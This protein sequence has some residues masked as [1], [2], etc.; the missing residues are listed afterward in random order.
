[1]NTAAAPTAVVVEAGADTTPT[2][3]TTEPT[4]APATPVPEPTATPA[5]PLP[6]SEGM[7]QVAPGFYSI[8]SSGESA[9]L[10]EFWIDRFEVTNAQ[11]AEFIQ[12]T[13]QAAPDYWGAA[14]IPGELGGH[15]VE[16]ITWQ[17]A[18]DFCNWLD[19]RLPTEA[20]WEAAARGPEGWLYPWG[21]VRTA[22][23]LPT[24]GTYP[25]GSIA[26]NRSFF[27][28]FDMAGNVWEWVDQ[29]YEE[30][31]QGQEVI[32]GGANN[33]QND[34][35]FRAVGDPESSNMFANAGIRCAAE[36]VDPVPDALL[37]MQDDFADLNSGWFQAGSPV[38]PYFYGY[39]PTDFY[40][41]QVS[42]AEDCLTVYEEENFDNFMA[43]IDIFIAATNTEVGRF[44]YGL[45]I[46]D[47][48]SEFYAFTISPRNQ[49]W[50]VLKGTAEGMA[51][52]DSGT[53]SSIQGGTQATRDR[54]FVIANG[55]QMSFFLN[56][57]LVSRVTDDTLTSGHIGFIVQTLDETYAHTH[58]D[59]IT[60]WQLPENVAPAQSDQPNQE[61]P[62][63]SPIC[64]GSVSDD[65]LLVSFV[66]YTIVDGDTLSGI[67]NQFGV[68]IDDIL[69]ANG[70]T[71]ESPSFIRAGASIIIPIQT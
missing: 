14:N 26:E 1:M 2:A 63:D 24:S 58:Y 12:D 17:E 52:M 67:S 54:L 38:G 27:G 4:A 16:S 40:H 65:N 23:P 42:E 64:R 61:Y 19:K 22:V 50:Q 18:A 43:E 9:E 30:V 5:G 15:P 69:G 28:A 53:G 56:G 46:R 45:L 3:E 11:Y 44:R 70:R 62:I 36:Q 47:N 25:V 51:V 29:P 57:G 41:V 21:N 35:V 39:H 48:G 66:S 59:D 13:G 37:L 33:F 20:E 10:A 6:S 60:V 7:V 31:P 32:K 68:S 49:T 55:P 71:I 8:G 34:L